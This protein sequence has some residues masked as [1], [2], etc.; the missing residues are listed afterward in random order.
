MDIKGTT[1]LHAL[2]T[3]KEAAAE[4]ATHSGGDTQNLSG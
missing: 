3:L 4:M 2:H 1:L